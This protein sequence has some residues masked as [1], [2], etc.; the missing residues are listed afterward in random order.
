MPQVRSGGNGPR[1]SDI[2]SSWFAANCLIVADLVCERFEMR[3]V[4]QIID[5][6]EDRHSNTLM[7]RM[8]ADGRCDGNKRE[9]VYPTR[10]RRP[11]APG[12]P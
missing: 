6:A 5:D 1:Y 4:M 8:S 9:G 12:F 10:L 3:T 7:Q 11:D 2:V